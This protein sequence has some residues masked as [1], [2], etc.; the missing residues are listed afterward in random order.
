MRQHIIDQLNA[1]VTLICDRYAFSGVAYS[2]AKVFQAF[3]ISFQGLDFEWCKNSDR[4]LI[5]PDLTLYIDV[6]PETI[7]QRGNF[8]DERYEKAE[9]QRKVGQVYDQFKNDFKDSDHWVTID[10]ESKS[11]EEMTE[12]ILSKI[13]EYEN[14]IMP[15]VDFKFMME[16]L[17]VDA[18]KQ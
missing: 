9:F 16:S 10:G 1:G 3:L 4:G 15:K 2:A 11:V 12:T 14:E 13:E 7:Q 17:F 5:Q 6:S 18:K 8:G